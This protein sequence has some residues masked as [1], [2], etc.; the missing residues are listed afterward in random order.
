MKKVK[1]TIAAVAILGLVATSASAN[2]FAPGEGLYIGAFAGH[3][4]GHVNAPLQSTFMTNQTGALTVAN[5]HTLFS[6]NTT[7][8]WD[9]NADLS[10]ATFTAPVAG[11]YLLNYNVLWEGNTSDSVFE[12]RITT[13]N[14]NYSFNRNSRQYNNSTEY[15][16]NSGT[17]IA[18][19][20]ANDT[21]I[22]THIGPTTAVHVE[23]GFK[24]G[25]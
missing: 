20:D 10:G 23:L 5:G 7:E 22:I 17:A 12:A 8:R 9:V 15:I 13:S 21:A 4:A 16:A 24:D 2:A 11:K 6:A 3:S 14:R 19:M 25:Y 18:D 1:L